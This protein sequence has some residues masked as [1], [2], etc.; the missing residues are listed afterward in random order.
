MLIYL[1][2][3]P[4]WFEGQHWEAKVYKQDKTDTLEVE[5]AYTIHHKL[6]ID[7]SYR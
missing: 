7:W 4:Q 1:Q 5:T 6:H 2:G 3:K